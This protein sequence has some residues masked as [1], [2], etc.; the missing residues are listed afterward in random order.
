[1]ACLCGLTRPPRQGLPYPNAE[2]PNP[3]TDAA[4][5]NSTTE[6]PVDA[7]NFCGTSCTTVEK[8][9]PFMKLSAWDEDCLM[10]QGKGLADETSQDFGQ[11]KLPAATVMKIQ[12]LR[13]IR[14][15]LAYPSG[16]YQLK[17]GT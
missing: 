11:G 8:K 7:I 4:S 9:I 17:K 12:K 13:K 10:L 5:I 16:H 1:M 2:H 3:S 14:E 15:V 6:R